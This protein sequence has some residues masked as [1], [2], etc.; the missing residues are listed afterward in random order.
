LNNNTM[1]LNKLCE[2][3]ERGEGIKWN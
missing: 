3:L 1:A 2:N